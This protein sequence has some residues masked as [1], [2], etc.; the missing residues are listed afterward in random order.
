MT[1]AF[2]LIYTATLHQLIR[3]LLEK[4]LCL[5]IAVTRGTYAYILLLLETMLT[6]AALFTDKFYQLTS[7]LTQ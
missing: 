2:P 3:A 7:F 1:V 5:Y 6:M 4:H